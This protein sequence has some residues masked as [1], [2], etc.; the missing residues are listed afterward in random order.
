MSINTLLYILLIIYNKKSYPNGK[1]TNF[2]Y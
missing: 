1:Y 2:K